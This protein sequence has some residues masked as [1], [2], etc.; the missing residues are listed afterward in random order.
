[1][2]FFLGAQDPAIKYA[3]QIKAVADAL[4]IDPA[5]V[6]HE[7]LRVDPIAWRGGYPKY[8]GWILKQMRFRNIVLPEDATRVLET[9]NLLEEIKRVRPE[10]F[11]LDI[12]RYRTIGELEEATDRFLEVASGRE[13]ERPRKVEDLP[14]GAKIHVESENYRILEVTHP[15]TC[16]YLARGTK[17]CTR[18]MPNADQYIE[19]YGKL[20]VIL[21]RD[22][23]AWAVYGQYTPDYGQVMDTRNQP[24]SIDDEELAD[25]MG[26][27]LDA[28]DAADNALLYAQNVIRRRWPLAEPIILE[29][30]IRVAVNYAKYVIRGP[31]PEAEP[32]IATNAAES[33]LYAKHIVKGP[34]PLGEP[35][36]AEEGHTAYQYA[37]EILQDRF[38]L[39]EPAIARL[40]GYATLYAQ[41]V[42]YSRFFEAEPFIAQDPEWAANYAKNILHRRF[43]E[44]EP[45]IA[46]SPKYAYDY[47]QQIIGGPWPMGEA[48]IGQDPDTAVAYARDVLGGPFPA[49]EAAIATD[50]RRSYMYA[51]DVLQSRFLEGEPAIAKEPQWAYF[52]ARDVI[53]GRWPVGEKGIYKNKWWTKEYEE[54]FA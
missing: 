16:I 29:S 28:P 54:L 22:R 39:G 2:D 18:E 13:M 25:L 33:L 27:D 36:I 35:T 17:W 45:A 1:V 46:S 5:S 52:Y 32:V 20:F 40:P 12:N 34:W 50:A 43:P 30:I 42:L 31:W 3:A 8:L 48:A 6:L 49:G 38:P 21:K 9:L 19:R 11:I 24:L 26:P 23:N 47:M 37:H 51:R 53:R 41:N 4:E 44:G 10:G 7:A 14:Q 15:D